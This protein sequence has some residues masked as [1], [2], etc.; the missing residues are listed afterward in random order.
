MASLLS[1]GLLPILLAVALAGCGGRAAIPLDAATDS[2]EGPDAA[3]GVEAGGRG[4]IT[5]EHLTCDLSTQVCCL[6]WGL[7][8]DAPPQTWACVPT[9]QCG[10][11]ESIG[12]WSSANCTP[13]GVCCRTAPGSGTVF[14]SCAA[15]CPSDGLQLCD[16][17][18]ECPPGNGCIVDPGGWSVCDRTCIDCVNVGKHAAP[19][20]CG[21]IAWIASEWTPA[22]S[23]TLSSIRLYTT[24]RVDPAGVGQVAL[25]D[26]A[27]ADASA[28]Q[29]ATVLATGVLPVKNTLEWDTAPMSPPVAVRQGHAYFIA[30]WLNSCSMAQGGTATVEYAS[31]SLAGPWTGP[32]SNALLAQA[33]Q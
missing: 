9:D 25:L 2:T 26:S 6:S 32:S 3:H 30:Q 29:P 20:G 17:S 10:G 12:C 18:A 7:G 27:P 8:M 33:C 19:F 24:G 11:A 13:G 1:H 15:K 14:S 5:C 4:P 21:P 23:F 31:S 22:Q 28:H 16:A